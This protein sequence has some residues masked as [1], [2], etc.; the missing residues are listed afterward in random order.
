MNSPTAESYFLRNRRRL[1]V[2]FD[3]EPADAATMVLREAQA[4]AYWAVRS[5]F[6]TRGDPAIV[7]MPTGSGKTAVM[8]LVALG[9]ARNRLLVIAPSRVV[10]EQIALEFQT[11]GTAR[12]AGCLPDDL[13]AP[14]VRTVRKQLSSPHKWR[15]LEAYH[16]VVATPKCVSP[17]EMGVCE[18]APID[19]FDTIFF[20][21]AHHLPASTWRALVQHFADAR[22]ATF[23]A[24]PYRNDK[25]PIPGEIVY[26]YPLGR[27]IEAGIYRRIEFVPVPVLGTKQQRNSRLARRAKELL[28]EERNR[29]EAKLLVRVGRIKDTQPVKAL[30]E[31]QGLNL[32]IVTSD[33][34]WSW[35]EAA[36]KRAAEDD[37]CHGLICV[38]M[39]GEGLDLPALRIAVMHEP[40]RS[41]PITLQFIGRIC[42]TSGQQ[43]DTAKLL[44]IPDEVEEH[45]RALYQ[46]DANW[47]VLIPGLAD[48]AVGREKAR[49]Q[50]VKDH[51]D[52]ASQVGQVSV[53]TL[54]PSF[55][56]AVYQAEDQGTGLAVEP[57]VGGDT[58]LVQSL[59]SG[60]SDSKEWRVLITRSVGRPPWTTSD[61]LLDANHDLHIYYRVDGVLFECTSA[62]AI[63]RQVRRSFEQAAGGTALRLVKKDRIEQALSQRD[64]SAYFNVGMRRV[65]YTSSAIA[66]YKM[67]TGSHAEDTIR[68]A[69]GHFFAV[70]HVF[71]RV[72]WNGKP[73][74]LG[75]S[76]QS[77]KIWSAARDHLKEFTEWCDK[78]AES[79]TNDETVGLPHLD[80]LKQPVEIKELSVRP[81]VATFCETFFDHLQNGLS[82]ELEDHAGV[83]LAI[84]G[85][86]PFELSVVRHSWRRSA[87]H[88]C[89]LIL[90][91][92]DVE[93][94]VQYDASADEPYRFQPGPTWRRCL[95]KVPEKGRFSDHSLAQYFSEFTPILFL[96]DGSAVLGNQAYLS[97]PRQDTL[98]A[99]LCTPVNW[100][101]LGCDISVE[102]RQ[103]PAGR[104]SVL[105]ATATLLR[106]Q[107]GEGA[108][109]FKDHGV[110]EIADYVVF[111]PASDG[112]RV[113]LFH[114]KASSSDKAGA[115][116][117]DA[118]EVLGQARKCA[119]W[120]YKGHLFREVRTRIVSAPDRIAQGC[121]EDFDRAASTCTPQTAKYIVHVVQPGFLISKIRTWWD[122]S[123][124]LMIVSLRD[125]LASREGVSLH[126]IG[127]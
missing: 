108:V 88:K 38:G 72:S 126:V 120:L 49:R 63:A 102:D 41:F 20:D 123:I 42:R 46:A 26:S 62:P 69:D 119:R 56:V 86:K 96:T 97:R 54:R 116:Q 93:V 118:F 15:E 32:Q 81:Y 70:G 48:A 122:S 79:L 125:E 92:G 109:V 17:K 90:Q 53:H 61:S 22:V 5:H 10:R 9:L 78:L 4:G 73:L 19:L 2:D 114:C 91:A 68:A 60:V 107:L 24:T 25:K 83:S 3:E 27:A 74:P 98:P 31:Q 117:A 58:E 127:S 77:G 11:L 39:L 50:F 67:M 75:V 59:H 100:S 37:N 29:G 101:E 30:Y 13:V 33:R 12:E 6:T 21:E 112:L 106:R 105:D 82:L 85:D 1:N 51:W 14:R 57:A 124:R 121:I 71:G 36:I 84:Q 34:S 64:V 65:A 87:P 35:N 18:D 113:H 23:T 28:H 94:A 80:H 104:C 89:R 103:L 95:V 8:T 16:V 115:R 44:A 40:H 66:S 76:G 47:A 45:T 99:D 7:V 55:S 43:G 52:P 110:G 111:E